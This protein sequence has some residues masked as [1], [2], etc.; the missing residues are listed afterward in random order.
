MPYSLRWWKAPEV[1]YLEPDGTLA[2]DELISMVSGIIALHQEA[3]GGK[4]HALINGSQLDGI[5]PINAVIREMKRLDT[6]LPNPGMNIVYGVSP[7]RRYVM[8]IVMRMTT[9][10][11]RTFDSRETAETFLLDMIASEHTVQEHVESDAD[12]S[13]S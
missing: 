2:E 10:R 4:V 11:Y 8:E 12:G 9:S 13:Q 7:L 1:I 6:A 5:P 3:N